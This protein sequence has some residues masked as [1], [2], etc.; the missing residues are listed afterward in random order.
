MDKLKCVP[1][2]LT[3]DLQ[4]LTIFDIGGQ[5]VA[6]V[7]EGTKEIGKDC[8]CDTDISKVYVPKSVKIIGRGAF[9]EC[10]CLSEVIFAE[11][12]QLKEIC[13]NAFHECVNLRSISLPEGLEAVGISSF[14]YSGLTEIAIPR[15]TRVIDCSAFSQCE[16]IHTVTFQEG[17]QLKK[18]G[19]NAF[20]GCKQLKN[21]SLPTGLEELGASCF[22]DTGIA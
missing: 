6:A 16:N 3:R 18:I 8:F 5:K 2:V 9:R 14:K 10:K 11:D 4:R 7:P 12:S 15:T 20:C 17:S 21:I 13:E 1:A 19:Y 22:S